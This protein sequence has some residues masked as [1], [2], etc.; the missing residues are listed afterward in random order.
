MVRRQTQTYK[1]PNQLI[2]IN[3]AISIDIPALKQVLGKLDVFAL[4]LIMLL[5]LSERFDAPDLLP[6]LLVGVH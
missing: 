2:L 4:L 3:V 5:G 6:F 1:G